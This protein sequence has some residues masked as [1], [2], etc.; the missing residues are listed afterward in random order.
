MN[1]YI[2]IGSR[3]Y[4]NIEVNNL[5]DKF[6]NNIRFNVCI[7]GNNCGTKIDEH[8]LNNHLYNNVIINN[9]KTTLRN[10]TVDNKM[11][12]KESLQNFISWSNRNKNKW[13]KIYNNNNYHT[14]YK[15]MNNYFKKQGL[16]QLK[17][18]ARVGYIGIYNSLINYSNKKIFV[19]GF[20]LSGYDN[21]FDYLGELKT[22]ICHDA[23][24]EQS[25]LI[26]MHNKKLI[27]AS[28]CCLKD[29]TI[30]T[31]DCK[32][33]LPSIYIIQLLL[34]CFEIIILTNVDEKNQNAILLVDLLKKDITLNIVN[35][36]NVHKII[37]KNN[38]I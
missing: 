11:Y 32:I 26:Q 19:F 30:P 7:P 2:I 35:E 5:L 6:N 13:T 22:S 28:L 1:N 10:Y 14:I 16:T 9:N 8:F 31:L 20:S 29:E 23:I 21:K 18:P 34:K 25:I 27:D 17:K 12:T 33:I 15:N 24:S 4:K 36:S 3:Y 37:I 38:I